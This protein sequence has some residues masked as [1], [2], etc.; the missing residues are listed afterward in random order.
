MDQGRGNPVPRFRRDCLPPLQLF[1]E[2]KLFN[3][4]EIDFCNRVTK[5]KVI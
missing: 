5:T 4:Y 1:K 3:S 2:N